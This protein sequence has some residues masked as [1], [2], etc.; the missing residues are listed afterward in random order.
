LGPHQL[1]AAADWLVV[2]RVDIAKRE[3]E[4]CEERVD[5]AKTRGREL[6]VAS[7]GLRI[8]SSIISI[9]VAACELTPPSSASSDHVKVHPDSSNSSRSDEIPCVDLTLPNERE[10]SLPVWL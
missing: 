3:E 1:E 2:E 10:S 8:D 6:R 7:C 5:M 9:L 4:S